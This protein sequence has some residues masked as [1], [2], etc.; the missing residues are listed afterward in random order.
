MFVGLH[1]NFEKDYSE[2]TI[3]PSRGAAFQLHSYGAVHVG[4][5]GLTP[6]IKQFSSQSPTCGLQ[7][8]TRENRVR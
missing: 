8:F 3:N 1:G 7:N 6:E 4:S 2:V 5:E